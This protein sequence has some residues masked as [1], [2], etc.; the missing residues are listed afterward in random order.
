MTALSAT[1]LATIRSAGFT[2][3]EWLRIWGY[4]GTTWG[5]DRCGCIDDR[6]IGHHHEGADGCGCLEAMISDAVAWRRA[7][8]S[9]NSVELV[10]GPYGLFQYVHVTTPGA[11]AT[12][13]ASRGG[14]GERQGE[15]EIRIE[16]RE[17]WS[18]AVT[19]EDRHGVRQMVIRF[20]KIPPPAETAETAADSIDKRERM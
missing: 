3:A 14:M 18:I 9:P 11:V 16:A 12:V 19:H 2:R 20:A 4:Q 5:G 15:S 13:S 10:G 8:R 1:A 7:T 6:C 17:G